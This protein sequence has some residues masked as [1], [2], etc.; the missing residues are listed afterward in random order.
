MKILRLLPA[1]VFVATMAFTGCKPKDADVKANIEKEL[2]ANPSTDNVMVMVDKGVVTLS[3]EVA[4]DASKAA[5]YDKVKSMKGV[6]SVQDN[7]VVPEPVAP[8]TITPDDPLMMSVK[9]ATKDYP[10]VTATVNDGVIIVTGEITK[11]KWQ[12]L[13]M[14][15]DGLNPKRVD[16]SALTIK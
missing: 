13:K 16:G 11:D 12:K 9:D 3:G 6:E 15:L 1:L 2:K 7:T 4:D 10:G 14:T 5:M 8:V